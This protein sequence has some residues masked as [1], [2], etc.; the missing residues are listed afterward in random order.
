MPDWTLDHVVVAS[1]DLET[2]IDDFGQIVQAK[3]IPGGKHPKTGTRNALVGVTDS[4]TYIELL[5][6]DPSDTSGLGNKMLSL[7]GQGL[8]LTPYHYSIRTTNLKAVR[9]KAL[10]LGMKP[11]AIK[12]FSRTTT[13]NTVLKWKC[14]FIRGHGLGGLVPCFVDWSGSPHPTDT[15][16]VRDDVGG[17]CLSIKV[18]VAAPREHLNK[19]RALLQSFEGVEFEENAIPALGFHIGICGMEG[20][21]I[22][23]KGYQPEG[24]DFEESKTRI[25]QWTLQ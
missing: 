15:M 8:S 10:S 9:T 17:T 11:T 7:H 19:V 3:P 4:K 1:Y 20:G 2:D 12:E 25:F 22:S 5:A 21:L 6:P 18:I 13:N 24:I 16:N 14:V 23:I